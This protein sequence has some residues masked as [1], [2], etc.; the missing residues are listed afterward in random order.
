MT[1]Y[2]YHENT[3]NY[4]AYY[5]IFSVSKNRKRQTKAT[6]K[7]ACIHKQTGNPI[8]TSEMCHCYCPASQE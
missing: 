5:I 7:N 6:K 8:V 1:G 4:S 2:S 3:M